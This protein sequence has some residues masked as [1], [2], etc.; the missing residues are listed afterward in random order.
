MAFPNHVDT[1]ICRYADPVPVAHGWRAVAEAMEIIMG[2]VGEENNVRSR[3]FWANSEECT[4][5]LATTMFGPYPYPFLWSSGSDFAYARDEL[6]GKI[7]RLGRTPLTGQEHL[8]FRKLAIKLWGPSFAKIW[9]GRPVNGLL[10][11]Y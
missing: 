11:S 2:F 7:E 1:L 6:M 8:R 4:V 9:P 10:M 3:W 5:L